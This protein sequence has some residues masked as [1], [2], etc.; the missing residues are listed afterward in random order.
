[1]LFW[2]D[3]RKIII[4]GSFHNHDETFSCQPSFALKTNAKTDCKILIVAVFRKISPVFVQAVS[5]R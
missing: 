2:D 4:S 5:E 1:M 3:C